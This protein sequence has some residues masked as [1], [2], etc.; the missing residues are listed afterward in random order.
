MVEKVNS[1]L[2]AFAKNITLGSFVLSTIT[3]ASNLNL[4]TFS[5][6]IQPFLL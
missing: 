5:H 4:A 3:Y 6:Q 2:F 1:M